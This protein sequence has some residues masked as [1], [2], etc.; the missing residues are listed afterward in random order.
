MPQLPVILFKEVKSS[1][2]YRIHV[3]KFCFYQFFLKIN[4]NTKVLICAYLIK[5]TID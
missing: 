5:N 1:M 2:S 4:K 3:W